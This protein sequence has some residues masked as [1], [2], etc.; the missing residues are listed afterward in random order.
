MNQTKMKTRNVTQLFKKNS[1]LSHSLL[2]SKQFSFTHSENPSL[3]IV[4]LYAQLP[5]SRMVHFSPFLLISLILEKQLRE[6]EKKNNNHH[7][8][9]DSVLCHKMGFRA[10][11]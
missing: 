2:Y 8:L 4:E 10:T 3:V 11:S 9:K 6:K 5:S 7:A 1:L